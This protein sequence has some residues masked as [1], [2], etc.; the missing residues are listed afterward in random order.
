VLRAVREFFIAFLLEFTP[1]EAMA[2]GALVGLL[3]LL[4][5]CVRRRARPHYRSAEDTTPPVPAAPTSSD[6]DRWLTCV[7]CKDQVRMRLFANHIARHAAEGYVS[8]PP[9]PQAPNGQPPHTQAPVRDSSSP[10]P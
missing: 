9:R 2:I 7:I 1:M 3:P 8:S 4:L 10:Q 5:V 6:S